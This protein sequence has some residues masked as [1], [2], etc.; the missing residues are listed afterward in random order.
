M[1]LTHYMDF[2]KIFICC[3]P[4]SICRKVFLIKMF[5]YYYYFFRIFFVFVNG[6]LLYGSKNAK[7]LL[8]LQITY[9]RK[10]F[11]FLKKKNV[12]F[13]YIFF[14][15]CEYFSFSL[16]GPYGSK[17]VKT[18]LLLQIAAESFQTFS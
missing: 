7:T 5:F 10:F 6:T 4:W 13:F 14:F 15:F 18:L 12:G 11:E 3:F 8:F 1:I 17:N 16:M 2:F 9:A